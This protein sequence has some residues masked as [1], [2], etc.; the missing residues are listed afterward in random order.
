MP[1]G[2]TGYHPTGS[3][4]LSRTPSPEASQSPKI[5]EL[6]SGASGMVWRGGSRPSGP[7]VN[8]PPLDVRPK[9]SS[10]DVVAEPFN[11][12][13]APTEAPESPRAEGAAMNA[14]WAALSRTSKSSKSFT[15]QKVEESAYGRHQERTGADM[16]TDWPL[17]T[18]EE[19]PKSRKRDF[20]R[21]TGSLLS[22][23]AKKTD[24]DA[25]FTRTV[26]PSRP[27]V[28]RKTASFLHLPTPERLDKSGEPG[29]TV[30][31]PKADSK[32]ITKSMIRALHSLGDRSSKAK[33]PKDLDSGLELLSKRGPKFEYTYQ[34][35]WRLAQDKLWKNVSEV[36]EKLGRMEEEIDVPAEATPELKAELDSLS[37]IDHESH[38][39][40]L[41]DLI[42]ENALNECNFP[43]HQAKEKIEA[44]MKEA[45]SLLK[46]Y[47]EAYR[48]FLKQKQFVAD[49]FLWKKEVDVAKADVNLM[50]GKEIRDFAERLPDLRETLLDCTTQTTDLLK[51]MEQLRSERAKKNRAGLPWGELKPGAAMTTEEVKLRELTAKC[52]DLARLPISMVEDI[53]GILANG[54]RVVKQAQASADPA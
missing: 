18:G 15:A 39:E 21:R 43:P 48:K 54:R 13:P 27:N 25:M 51:E 17:L 34:T 52:Q 12:P 35:T 4:E 3:H 44:T 10:G 45:G 46:K 30:D 36:H 28:L 29:Y 2:V 49:E 1:G 42:D 33:Q 32:S 19:A 41:K 50:Q 9:Y 53:K 23:K 40:Q 8:L 7:S 26:G 24:E 6:S 31:D 47:E 20:L 14:E 5:K 16:S 37:R 11:Y 38:Y 22:L